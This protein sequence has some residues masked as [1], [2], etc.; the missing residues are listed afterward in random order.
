MSKSS[1]VSSKIVSSFS[2]FMFLKNLCLGLANTAFAGIS[3]VDSN[4]R[5]GFNSP[6]GS[7]G[8]NSTLGSDIKGCDSFVYLG[9]IFG[10]PRLLYSSWEVGI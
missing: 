2:T 3:S 6:V 5:G 10:F 9:A 8:C 4:F 7:S 1:S